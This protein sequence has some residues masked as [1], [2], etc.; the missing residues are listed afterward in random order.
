[1]LSAMA[2]GR[3][4]RRFEMTTTVGKT[5]T[6]PGGD[7]GKPRAAL[8]P[9]ANCESMCAFI[10]LGGTRRYVPPEAQVLVHQIWL[11][12]RRDDATAASY[13]AEDLMLVQRDI[14]VLF[15]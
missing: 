13:T 11:G 4:I 10:L 8:S 2:L 7:D 15:R 14:P 3:A 12:D 5:A 9:K 6:L 1:M